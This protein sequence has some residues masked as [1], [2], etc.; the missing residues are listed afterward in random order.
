MMSTDSTGLSQADYILREEGTCLISLS[1]DNLWRAYP[2]DDATLRGVHQYLIQT[3]W[4]SEQG[5]FNREQFADMDEEGSEV[6]LSTFFSNI[7][8]AVLEYLRQ[9]GHET[10]VRRMVHTDPTESESTGA[11]S[12]RPDAFLHLT[13]GASPTS[14]KFKW[15]DLTCPFEFKF[16]GDD[17]VDIS[18]FWFRD[19]VL[20]PYRTTSRWYKSSITSCA[21]TPAEYSPLESLYV[22]PC[23]VSG[24]CAGRPPSRSP[25][26]TGSRFVQV[27]ASH[28]C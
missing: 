27:P 20:T 8:N 25:S 16:G 28:P 2:P 18:N 22:A 14:G 15:R 3:H 5:E 23:S 11:T 17:A 19:H 4:L 13:T 7:F 24:F 12:Y 6:E 21:R 26:S 9:H 1:T 10:L